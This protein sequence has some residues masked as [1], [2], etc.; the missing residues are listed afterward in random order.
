M[1]PRPTKGSRYSWPSR[2][3]RMMKLIVAV[4]Q[5]HKLPDVKE[6]S[7]GQRSSR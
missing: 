7:P 4:I 2:K 6:A 1:D 5:P 3:V